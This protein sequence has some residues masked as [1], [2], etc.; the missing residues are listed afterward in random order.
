[1]APDIRPDLSTAHVWLEPATPP[2]EADLALL[3]AAEW[4]RMAAFLSP[5]DRERYGQAHALK[6]RALA[7][8]TG[9]APCGLRFAAEGQGRPF[10]LDEAGAPAPWCFSL[11]HCKAGVAVVV[12]HGAAVGIDVEDARR[13]EDVMPLVLKAAHPDEAADMRRL[14]PEDRREAFLRLWTRK[15]ALLKAD[16]T[17]LRTDPRT[18]ITGCS[19]TNGPIV[20]RHRNTEWTLVDLPCIWGAAAVALAGA[21][22]RL[23]MA[24]TDHMPVRGE[25]HHRQHCGISRKVL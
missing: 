18:V 13:L 20:L 7:A 4:A 16:G 15:E 2:S 23:A 8:V 17:G 5:Q 19:K 12:R 3:D 21:G 6:R 11:S 9:R 1:M 25:R 14:L 24:N 10:L 22:A